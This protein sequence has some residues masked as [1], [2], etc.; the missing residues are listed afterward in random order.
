MNIKSSYCF[1]LAYSKISFYFASMI[2]RKIRLEIENSLS[3][4]PIVGILGSRQIG[5]TTLAKELQNKYVDSI[6]LDL[7]LPSDVNKLTDAEFYFKQNSNKL[8]IIDEIQKKPE[9]FPILRAIV[10]QNRKPGMFLILGSA[11]PDVLKQSAESLAGRIIYH[12]LPQLQLSEIGF[13]EESIKSLWLKGGYPDSYLAANEDFS[14]QWRNSFIQ[15]FLERDIPQFG[16]R[17][18]ATQLR[19]FWIML[20]HNHGQLWNGSKIANSLGVTQPTTKHY[21]DIL[22]DTF[23]IRQLNPFIANTKKRLIKSPKV[24]VRDSGIVHTL[25]GIKTYDDLLSHPVAG[26]SWEGFIIEQIINHIK[27]SYE[28]YFYRTNAGAE[29]DLVL[30]KGNLNSI[31]VEVK[32]T[33]SPK[34]G[35]SFWNSFE[36]LECKE[37]YVIYPGEEVFKLAENV[38]ACPIKYFIENFNT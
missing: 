24:Y 30:T 12:E 22:T 31:A 8:L 21:L 23:T 13:T 7:E 5:K 34:L 18:P 19:K 17:V 20:A 11:S 33:L 16:L 36:E 14:F 28:F 35:K 4:S 10:D 32:L 3:F 2:K 25:L 37:G 26:H 1:I 38:T 15:T 6:Y 9:L 27:N 29:L